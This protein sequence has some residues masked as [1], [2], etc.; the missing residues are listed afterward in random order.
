VLTASVVED[1]ALKIEFDDGATL[2]VSLRPEDRSGPEAI[3]YRAGSKVS[4]PILE[5]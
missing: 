2:S 4:D 5:F 3:L 1:E